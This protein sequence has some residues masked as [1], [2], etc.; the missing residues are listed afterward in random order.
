MRLMRGTYTPTILTAEPPRE[1]SW[2]GRLLVPGLLDGVHRFIIEELND[3]HVL[4]TQNETFRGPI[5]PIHKLLVYEHTRR[6]FEEMNKAL[7][8][9]AEN[10]EIVCE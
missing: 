4:F 5:T 10:R 6:S 9:R 1:L 8:A 7:K 2:V 3:N